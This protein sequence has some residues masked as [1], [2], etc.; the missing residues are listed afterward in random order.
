MNQKTR[1]ICHA[2]KEDC[3]HCPLNK[4]CKPLDGD[5]RYDRHDRMNEAAVNVEFKGFQ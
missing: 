2:N 1:S 3:R 5:G 4:S